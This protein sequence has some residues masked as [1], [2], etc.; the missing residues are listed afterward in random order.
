MKR[1]PADIK[2]ILLTGSRTDPDAAEKC[3]DHGHG[4]P[5]H[6]GADQRGHEGEGRA[7]H[8]AVARA[9]YHF[10]PG[11]DCKK[12][13]GKPNAQLKI[14]EIPDQTYALPLGWKL[15][16]ATF[17]VVRWIL[18][19]PKWVSIEFCN[20]GKRSQDGPQLDEKIVLGYSCVLKSVVDLLRA[21]ETAR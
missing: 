7:G 12:E 10:Y 8:Q 19:R 18:G 4:V 17:E 5:R 16:R 2:V 14:V 1:S 6:G 13:A 3:H 21:S 15:S 9:C 11:E 20:D